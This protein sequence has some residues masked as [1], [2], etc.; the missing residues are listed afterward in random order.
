MADKI[1]YYKKYVSH[2]VA[3][4]ISPKESFCFSHPG[5][6]LQWYKTI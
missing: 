3:V 6:E 5:R 4:E 1:F 2:G